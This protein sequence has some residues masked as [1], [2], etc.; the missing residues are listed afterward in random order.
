MMMVHYVWDC[1]TIYSKNK[2]VS[3]AYVRALFHT[4]EVAVQTREADAI[5]V[6]HAPFWDC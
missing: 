5:G 1:Q 3:R 2:T 6:L 4:Q